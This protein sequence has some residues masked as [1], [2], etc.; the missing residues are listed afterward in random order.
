[1]SYGWLSESTI[2]PRKGRSLQVPKGSTSLLQRL[3]KS[4]GPSGKLASTLKKAGKSKTKKDPL[5][6]SNPGVELR[7][8]V[9]RIS[10]SSTNSRIRERL[11]AKAHIYES[12][13]QGLPVSDVECVEPLVDF[14]TK[15]E[16]DAAS[17]TVEG[18]EGTVLVSKPI[19]PV[20]SEAPV[21]SNVSLADVSAFSD[22]E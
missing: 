21:T 13:S 12:M 16:L 7:N 5:D 9:D 3:I 6:G 22:E 10:Q 14:S 1:M 19:D 18:P 8:R 20:T 2:A 4:H 15:R 17:C 11:S